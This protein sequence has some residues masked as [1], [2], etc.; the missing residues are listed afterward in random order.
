MPRNSV[1]NMIC[2]CVYISIAFC[3]H[4]TSSHQLFRRR[5]CNFDPGFSTNQRLF[6]FLLGLGWRGRPVVSTDIVQQPDGD[7]GFRRP[8]VARPPRPVQDAVPQKSRA[9]SG[10]EEGAPGRITPIPNGW[11]SQSSIPE[12][13]F[14]IETPLHSSLCGHSAAAIITANI[15]HPRTN[16]RSCH[17]TKSK[18]KRLNVELLFSNKQKN[19][20]A[21]KQLYLT[22]YSCVIYF[23]IDRT[24]VEIQLVDS[25]VQQSC[26][27]TTF[28]RGIWSHNYCTTR[29]PTSYC[30]T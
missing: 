18:L 23:T 2:M 25:R 4:Q 24:L 29:F 11:A 9:Q 14:A 13:R 17:L 10:Q 15:I 28:S 19:V 8:A 7:Q 1:N 21:I 20:I 26:R 5:Q 3:I 22:A 30:R 12:T 6:E 16:V 27:S